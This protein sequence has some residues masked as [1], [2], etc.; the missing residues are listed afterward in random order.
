MV[1]KATSVKVTTKK[2]LKEEKAPSQYLKE[3]RRRPTL[4]ELEAKVYLFP[5]SNVP[6]ILDEFLAKKVIDHPES[7]R[8]IGLLNLVTRKKRRHQVVLR[9]R[10]PKTRATSDVNQ[11]QPSKSV[12]PCTSQKI[13]G[14]SSQ[15]VQRP[16]TLDEFFSG[17][18]SFALVKLVKHMLIPSQT[19]QREGKVNIIQQ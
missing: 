5:Y 11:L 13:N 19:K 9:I 17:K 10:L 3:E 1:V 2:K 4:K 18:N 8:P 7:K 12:K 16:V 15:K 6:M 14:S